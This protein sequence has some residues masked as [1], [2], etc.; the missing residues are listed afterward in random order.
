MPNKPEIKFEKIGIEERKALLD[1]LGY[2]VNED[3]IIIVKETGREYKDPITEEVVFIEN[4]SVLP[5]STVIINT[6]ELSLA[7]YV[8]R[9]LEKAPE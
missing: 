9:Y 5:G 2:E 6:S 3:G 7:E 1:I 4:A 8:T